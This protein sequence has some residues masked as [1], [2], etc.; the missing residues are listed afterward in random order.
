MKINT[1]IAAAGEGKAHP[2]PRLERILKALLGAPEVFRTVM[3]DIAGASNAPH[4]IGVLRKQYGFGDHGLGKLLETDRKRRT[5]RDGKPCKPGIY[6]LTQEGKERAQAF[7]AWC[8]SGA[9]GR[10]IWPQPDAPQPVGA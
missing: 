4:Y 5:D 2:H 6:F 1:Q 3:D 8:E 7:L 9:V 10:F